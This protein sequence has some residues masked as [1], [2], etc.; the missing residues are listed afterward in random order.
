MKKTVIFTFFSILTLLWGLEGCVTRV[1]NISKPSKREIRKA[2][3]YSTWMYQMPK[4]K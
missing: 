4:A 2:M 3:Q 1:P